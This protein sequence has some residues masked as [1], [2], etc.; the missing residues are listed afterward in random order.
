M[1]APTTAAEAKPNTRSEPLVWKVGEQLL[2]LSTPVDK[3]E[4]R[5]ITFENEEGQ[6][7]YRHSTAHIMAEAVQ[8]LFPETKVTIGP[9]IEGGFYYDFARDEPFTEANLEAIEARMREIIE[10][11]RPFEREEISKEEA[12]KLFQERDESYKVEILDDLPDE[13][14]SIYR[15]GKWLDLCRGPHVPSTG[16]IGAVKLLSVAGAYW[17]GDERN[18][19]LQR[20]YGTSFPT[21]EGVDEY[22]HLREEARRRDHRV[23]GKE[24]AIYL[25]HE[26][27]GSGL[28]YW[29]PRGAIL[30]KVIERFWEDEHV[31]NGYELVVIPHLAHSRLFQTSGHY[32]FYRENMFTLEVDDEEYVAKPMNCPGHILI[33][34][35]ER[36]SYRELPIRYA[37][38]GTVYR[39]ERSGVL[40]GMLRV[41][42]F[43]QDDAHIFCTPEQLPG[44]ILGVL[45]F[46]LYMLSTFGFEQFDVELSVRD[47]ARPEK[48]AGS[49][50]EWESAEAALVQALDARSLPYK[51]CEGEA[52]FYGPKIDVKIV[53]ALGRGWQA[54]T[55][56]FDFNLP[57]RFDLKY[58]GVDGDLHTPYMVHRALLGSLERFV[59]ALIEHTAGAFPFWLA[60]V[61]AKVLPITD[62]NHDFGRKVET[63]LKEAGIR[64]EVDD[65]NEK[66]GYKIRQGRLERIPYLLVVG[67]R[68][69]ESEQVAVRD[70]TEGDLG[71]MSLDEFL[72]RVRPE[73]TPKSPAQV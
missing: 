71:A 29:L 63:R 32:D 45:D 3:A 26:S 20:I 35:H 19:M 73:M 10:E 40:H 28:V 44:E 11:D 36:R 5:P 57:R 27:A 49:D 13:T 34:Q 21:Q 30:R 17:R 53:D 18:K 50:E 1:K 48:Y 12:R 54:S 59:G 67:D 6:E 15:Q 60:P 8:D 38:L 24:L 37:E 61:Q 68:E 69:Q 51:R 23:L 52:V 43:T 25:I 31:R 66:L 65:R 7:V 47:P 41:R 58:V 22:L 39:N 14:F 46:T 42:G 9:P 33:Y 2:D 4:A 64:A 56:Q 72:D 16:L 70:R 55:I 62:R